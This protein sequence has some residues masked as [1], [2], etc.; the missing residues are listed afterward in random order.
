MVTRYAPLLLHDRD[1]STPQT[2]TLMFLFQFSPV[3]SVDGLDRA[4][5]K[6]K[7]KH[8]GMENDSVPVQNNVVLGTG[9]ASTF[10]SAAGGETARDVMVLVRVSNSFL[11][12]LRAVFPLSLRCVRDSVDGVDS[13]D[14]LDR[15][16]R[17]GNG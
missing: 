14:G 9:S 8:D 12:P 15:A 6:S 3:D 4:N 1:D 11:R 17:K 7:C 16:N 2:H 10:G 5:A 13:V